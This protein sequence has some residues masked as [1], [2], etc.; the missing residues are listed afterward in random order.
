MS[1]K[2]DALTFV[3]S[4]AHQIY[5][6]SYDL[7]D[8]G[9][10]WGYIDANGSWQGSIRNVMDGVSLDS[11][12]YNDVIM[13]VMVSYITNLTIFYSMVYSGTDQ[14]KRQSPASLAFVRGIHQGLVNSTD[15]WPVIQNLIPFS[16]F[17]HYECSI[18]P[19]NG[20]NGNHNWSTLWLQMPWCFSTRASVATALEYAPMGSRCLSISGGRI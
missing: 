19:W 20:P 15:K 9:N 6:S 5:R 16:N 8:L 4:S 3:D 11:V 13:G 14:R 7:I 18:C 10:A 2:E 12:H 1:L 17:V